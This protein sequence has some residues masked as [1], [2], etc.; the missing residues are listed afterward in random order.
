[1]GYS[2]HIKR[3][4]GEINL[5]EWISVVNEINTARINNE[6]VEAKKPNIGEI[7]NISGNP[8][9]VD[10]LEHFGGVL[11]F[12]KKS[13]WVNAI[14]FFDGR[15]SFNATKDIENPNNPV[16]MVA[17]KLAKLLSAKIVGDE[18]EE[19]SW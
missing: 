16:R 11:G 2:L 18:G 13:R 19:Y 17:A 10:V 6:G 9:D 5:E 7:I 15:A 12:G 8:G 4:D 14:R 1:M 3:E